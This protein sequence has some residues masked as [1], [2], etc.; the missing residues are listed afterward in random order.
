MRKMMNACMIMQNMIIENA[1][2]IMQNMIIKSECK[3]SSMGDHLCDHQGPLFVVDHQV[4]ADFLA[5][6]VEVRGVD[7][8]A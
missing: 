6:H 4:F 8:H 1:C 5:M 2:M 7:A 3:S